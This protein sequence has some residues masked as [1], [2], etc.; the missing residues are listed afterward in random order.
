MLEHP[1]D[2]RIASRVSAQ[3]L[4]SLSGSMNDLTIIDVRGPGELAEGAVVGSKHI[5]LANLLER[6][7]ELD[8]TSPTVVYCAGGYRS[9]IAASTLRSL[10]FLDVSDIVGGYGAWRTQV[11]SSSGKVRPANASRK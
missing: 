10:G 7:G 2:V 8:P 6:V 3:Q 11:S 1:D 9:S 5:Q 4:E